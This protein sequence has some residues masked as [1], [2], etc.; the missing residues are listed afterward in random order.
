MY[1][2]LPHL[3]AAI[4]AAL[5]KGAVCR[6]Y[7]ESLNACWPNLPDDVQ[8]ERVAKFAAQNRWNVTCRMLGNLGRVAE[9]EKT[10]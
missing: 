3:Q 4:R 9:F 7:K 10:A 1:T 6:I 5:Q 2:T 8:A